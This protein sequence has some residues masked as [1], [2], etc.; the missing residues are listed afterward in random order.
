[1][2]PCVCCKPTSVYGDTVS[3]LVEYW[4]LATPCGSK[5]ITFWNEY[6]PPFNADPSGQS[7][8]VTEARGVPD[9]V[10]I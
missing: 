10:V 6:C 3:V 4:I 7:K 2:G 8:G 9:K 1:M 5:L